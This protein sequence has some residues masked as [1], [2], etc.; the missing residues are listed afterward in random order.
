MPQS[1]LAASVARSWRQLGVTLCLVGASLSA[2]TPP[3]KPL[4]APTAADLERG[5]KVYTTYCARCHGFDGSGGMGP[6]LARPKLRRAADE[7]GII[8][9]LV[10]G[11]P[12]TAMTAAWSL[13]ERETVQVAAYVRSLGRRAPEPLPGNPASGQAV[14]NRFGCAGCHIVGGLGSGVGP[15]LTDIGLL[16]GAAFLRESL[17]DPAAARPDRGVSYEPYSYPAYLVVRAQPRRGPEIIG[18]RLNEDTF[19]IQIRDQAGRL[20]SLR[21]ADL[22]RLAPDPASSLMPS[23]RGALS[24]AELDDLVA[25]LMTRGAER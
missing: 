17:L 12:G 24:T 10:D 3:P 13:S 2:Q 25:Y 5:A 18:V 11:V 9:V 16:R 15:E 4:A 8:G 1:S 21:K 20:H 23:Y 19:T 6:P 7:A 14:Y 22:E